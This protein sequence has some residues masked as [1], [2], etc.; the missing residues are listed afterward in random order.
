MPGLEADPRHTLV[1]V[2]G[3][4]IFPG[5]EQL[6][7]LRFACSAEGMRDYFLDPGRFGLPEGNLLWLFDA[8]EQPTSVYDKIEVFLRD[9]LARPEPD[10]PRDVIVYYVGH[11]FFG[12]D[13]SYHL[14]AWSLK[15]GAPEYHIVFERYNGRSSTRPGRFE[16]SI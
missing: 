8:T 1:I 3:A 11:G 2:I 10:G 4:S 6:S 14:A 16:S 12:D 9:A 7:N 5:N 13:R 15:T